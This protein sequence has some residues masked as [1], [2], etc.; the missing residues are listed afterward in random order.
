LM[1]PN[2][3][4]G[5]AITATFHELL[6]R[7]P[8]PAERAEWVKRLSRGAPLR[9]LKS[10]LEALPEHALARALRQ[11]IEAV[12]RTGLFDSAWYQRRYP[13]VRAMEIAP[14]KHYAA[15]GAYEDRAPN[16]WFDPAWYRATYKIKGSDSALLH[17]AS[18]G[19]GC[20]FKPSPNF[21]PSW[22][23]KTYG[24]G[25]SRSPL[26]DFLGRRGSGTVAPCAAMWPAL[27]LADPILTSIADDV[28]LSIGDEL[29]D[30]LVL[31][32]EGVFDENFYALHSGD[33]LASGGDLLRHYCTSGWREERRPNFYFD[34]KWYAATNPEVA[35]LN[36]NPLAHYVLVGEPEGRRPVVYFDPI[37]YR[38][39]Y[40]VP[41][42]LS[43]L[44]HFL[45][46]RRD[47]RVSPNALFDPIWYAGQRGE[48]VRAGRD[49]FARFLVTGLT[50]DYPPSPA[51]A[52]AE[53]RRRAM[54]RV[55]RHFRHLLD[56]AKDNPLVNYLLTT[57][58]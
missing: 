58:R 14:I 21:D 12:E 2:D 54:G 9:E 11:T 39:T 15:H 52:P 30:F 34:P 26:V 10:Q 56:P 31:R 32:S 55:S 4:I 49:P 46:H 28:F 47:G 27:G 45:A 22:Y 48:P 42:E 3:G 41:D 33:V 44:A 1:M 40:V 13:D 18:H 20:G 24:I 25:M 38:N 16:P 29:A 7:A 17:Y 8:D 50:E 37:W 57:Y 36:V 53:W 43:A 5:A 23:R 19:E 35:Q 51:F 6:D